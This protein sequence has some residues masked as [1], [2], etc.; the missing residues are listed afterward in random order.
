[1]ADSVI[2]K[3]SSYPGDD[4]ST[5]HY[6]SDESASLSDTY[7]QTAARFSPPL[8]Y[9]PDD[10]VSHKRVEDSLHSLPQLPQFPQPAKYGSFA[11]PAH[12][13]AY[14]DRLPSDRSICSEESPLH[15]FHRHEISQAIQEENPH[16]DLTFQSLDDDDEQPPVRST[17]QPSRQDLRRYHRQV[18]MEHQ[19]RELKVRQVRGKSQAP[20]Q[21][22][23]E[24]VCAVLFLLQLFVILGCA[25]KW[26]SSVFLFD[27]A[28]NGHKIGGRPRLMEQINIED[29]VLL[30]EFL[31]D[32]R[33]TILMDPAVVQSSLSVDYRAVLS[34]CVICCLYACILSAL[35]VGFMLIIAKSLIQTALVFS[36]L[37][38]ISWGFIGIAV[39]P[40]FGIIPV[41]G[42]VSLL[43]TVTYTLW[44]W[45]RIP[46]AA[47]NLY[48]ALCAVR[49]TADLA[50]MGMS[51]MLVSVIWCLMWVTAFSGIM[52]QSDV[53]STKSI[54]LFILLVVSFCWTNLVI[55]NIV[56]VTVASA[57][58]RWWFQPD[59]ISACCSSAVTKPLWRSITTSFGTICLGSLIAP[60]ARLLHFIA[61]LFCLRLTAAKDGHDNCCSLFGELAQFLRSCNRWG[62]TYVGLYGYS[63]NEG[64]SKALEVFEAREWM[65]VVNDD[66]IP[67]VLLMASVVIGGSTGIFGVL[68]EEVDGYTFTSLHKP[69]IIAF[70][71]GGSFGFVLSNILLLGVVGSAVNT[72]LVCFAAGPFEFDK[73]HPRLSREMRDMWSQQVWETDV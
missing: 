2:P 43:L 62:F 23:Q 41:M 30:E 72:I 11:V 15:F 37:L 66:L 32:G 53:T 22:W 18:R 12:L 51:M 56:Q 61:G 63:F 35:T 71:L 6:S 47:T 33:D 21:S 65:S 3:Y 7:F 55:K 26:G 46:F 67:N 17:R 27:E 48:V 39:Q 20:A 13:S 34:M 42:F 31:A 69:I 28:H 19:A 4:D 9:S 36:I 52:E 54:T 29:D 10:V 68:V 50:L 1:M 57:V 8:T 5:L 70:L 49:W 38:A 59:S 73:N 45:D 14:V 58:G 25:V 60:P 24:S 44:V 64:G 40:F 16:Q